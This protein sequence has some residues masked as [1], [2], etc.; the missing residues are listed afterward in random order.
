MAY[1]KNTNPAPVIASRVPVYIPKGSASDES[2]VFISVG[3]VNYL[4]PKGKTSYVPRHVAEVYKR[5]QYNQERLDEAKGHLNDAKMP[6][7]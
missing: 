6:I 4:L 5:S 7:F 1:T 2:N 3:G